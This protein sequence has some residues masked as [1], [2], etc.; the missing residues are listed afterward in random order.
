MHHQSALAIDAE[1]TGVDEAVEN[2]VKI[3]LD[4][5]K[6]QAYSPE[7]LVGEIERLTKTA[8]RPF[9]YYAPEVEVT[10]QEKQAKVSI[11]P[12]EPVRIQVI[13]FSIQGDAKSDPS[14]ISALDAY[15]QKKGDIL[16]HAPYDALREKFTSL[17]L[18]KGYFDWDLLEHRMEI[19]PWEN[20]ARLY[21]DLNSGERYH[22]GDTLFH[23][24]HIEIERLSNLLP[25]H[26]G[27]FY[28]ASDIAKLS[29]DLAQTRWFSLISV[30]PRLDTGQLALP[31]QELGFYNELDVNGV[32]P[33]PQQPQ[34]TSDAILAATHVMQVGPPSIPIDVVLAPADRHQFEFGVG[35]ST[36][37]GPR[38]RMSWN[39]PWVNRYGHSLNHDLYVSG[40]EQKFT[41]EYRMP[42]KDPLRD[43]YRLQYGLRNQDNNDIK[44]LEASVEF[45]RHWTFANDW[46]QTI[47]LRATYEDFTLAGEKNQ[48]LLL[49]PGVRWS[50]SRT[51][52]P[53][54][55][56]W[57]DSQQLTLQYSNKAWGSDADFFRLNGDTQWIRMLGDNNRFIARMNV[58]AI[59]TD[60]FSN[61]PSS[62]RF[63]AGGD[64]S[65]RGYSYESLSPRDSKGRLIGGQQ[66]FVASLE[67]QRR[68]T[69]KWWLASFID[70]GDAF[71]KWAPDDLYTGAGLG[72][73][74]IS[75]VGP[76]RFDVAHPFDNDDNFRIHFAIGPE[77]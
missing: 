62:L 55:P 56:T 37:V 8:M 33:S 66:R 12:G 22:F 58:G 74:W 59:E 47:Y 17:S 63:F 45:G 54:F 57:G 73:R 75:P 25:Y 6:S 52:H 50:R 14:F 53:N 49:Y 5:I 76:I 29:Q 9:G 27:D 18:Q 67:A 60:D 70:T 43:S 19:R 41:G 51:K 23:G 24:S 31:P 40:P 30:K 77:F 46:E 61:I 32:E 65:V 64:N 3:Y 13:D 15:P 69:G 2:N 71:T 16:E 42:L 28:L 10:L 68:L 26:T 34:L 1:V 35:F 20:S 4:P 48:V 21:L 7:R 36:D 11:K 38:A 72:V 44:T 39:Q